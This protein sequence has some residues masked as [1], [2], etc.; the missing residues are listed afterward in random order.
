[1]CYFISAALGP[2]VLLHS[3]VWR[4]RVDAWSERVQSHQENLIS[5]LIVIRI[6]PLPPHWMVNVVAPH[7]GISMWH[8]WISTFLG[9]SVMTWLRDLSWKNRSDPVT[10][11]SHRYRRSHLHS[12]PNRNYVGSN[13]EHER[14]PFD[15]LAKWSRTWR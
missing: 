5:Y 10:A 11:F 12:H 3:E 2:A 1:M 14:F 6:A 13:D 4:K 8:F 15:Q 7:L 9:K